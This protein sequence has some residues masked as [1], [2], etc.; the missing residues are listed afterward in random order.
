MIIRNIENSYKKKMFKFHTS[1]LLKNIVV[2]K[3]NTPVIKVTIPKY[4]IPEELK[5][6][7]NNKLSRLKMT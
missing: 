4:I 3:I 1:N 6:G 7:Y 5:N 2:H